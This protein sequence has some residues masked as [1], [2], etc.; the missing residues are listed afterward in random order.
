M[1]PDPTDARDHPEIAVMLEILSSGDHT[2]DDLR[3]EL[4]KRSIF[5]DVDELRLELQAR[6]DLEEFADG[7]WAHLPSLADDLVL[8]HE[9]T[10]EELDLGVLDSSDVE[11]W[12]QLADE[13]LPFADGG[14][15]RARL[16][17]GPGREL[18]VG[19]VS[20]LL[21]PAGWLAGYQSGDIVGLRLR[22]GQLRLEAVD[23][24]LI[25]GLGQHDAEEIVRVL[26][27]VAQ[28]LAQEALR[29][30]LEDADPLPGASL[31]SLV[32]GVRRVMPPAFRMPLPPL[33]AMLRALGL[34][35]WRG[36]VG[37]PGA[38]WLGEPPGLDERN[39]SGLRAW[40]MML[41]LHRTTGEMAEPEQLAAVAHSLSEDVAL[42]FAATQL[43]H[44]P[45]RDPVAAAL[46]E[47]VTGASRAV[48]LFLLA[49]A[50]EG[51][52][53]LLA[54]EGR[55]QE[56]VA[57]DPAL[58]IGLADLAELCALR[59]DAQQAWQLYQR[60]HTDFREPGFAALAPFIR[61][62]AGEV[63]RNRPCPCGSGRKYKMC[64]G[65]ELR[66]PLSK[67]APWVY[68]K[69]VTHAMRA[70]QADA[71]L[72]YAEIL[73]G[74][75]AS[76][77]AVD[78]AMDDPL[79]IDLALF[80]GE[81]LGDFVRECAVLLPA[82]E[83]ALAQS[84]LDSER[85]LLEV[86]STEPGR[87]LSCRD[88]LTDED[89]DVLDVTMSRSSQPLDLIYGRPLRD[90]EGALLMMDDPRLVPRMVRTR[91]LHLLTSDASGEDIAEFFAP[92]SRLPEMRTTE[93][94]EMVVCS[95][96]YD[97]ADLD[98]L[99][100]T[101][102]GD[103][104][105]TADGVLSEIAEVHGHGSVIRGSI[106]RAGDRLVVEANSIERLRRLQQRLLAVDPQAR[107]VDE[108]SVPIEDMLADQPGKGAGP[109]PPSG[110]SSEQERE[111]L[112]AVMRQHEDTW[113]DIA[114]PVLRGRTPREAA[115]DPSTAADVAA[116]LD[117]FEW[118]QR[119]ESDA[120]LMDIDRLRRE[121]GLA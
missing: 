16:I 69:A 70:R 66:H 96:R 60:A 94:E 53:D 105:E 55:L 8:T 101:L 64:H 80:D 67:R 26:A 72:G 6:G 108:S 47:S 118:T 114:L 95:A 113:P 19:S 75:E 85:R 86:V 115:A 48:P 1:P 17:G 27:D 59:G 39:R 92:H 14:E 104:Q 21:G 58:D 40:T 52:G 43:T 56:A 117:D 49:R 22:G 120:P 57:A 9:L 65:R 88:L 24:S 83:L 35:V 12:A 106:S 103:L 11:L 74:D 90:G 84:W 116:L 23:P 29:D 99:W 31:A 102:A 50:A 42:E 54:M 71:L 30:Y 68:T 38:P 79:A 107:L 33:T 51:R 3:R 45:K 109:G 28:S 82:D 18:P 13:G 63:S 100:A 87:G 61:P 4:G 7:V 46:L 91:L 98:E 15:V 93:G 25:E 76:Q 2:L 36:Y 81:L 97:V 5:V 32:A 20:G 78:R 111:A 89:I 37:L 73:A 77:K 44:E 110:L 10:E 112:A 62:P 121:L 34:E 41:A 119:R